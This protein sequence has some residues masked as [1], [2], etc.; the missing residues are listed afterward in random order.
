M[1]QGD[2]IFLRFSS[3]VCYVRIVDTLPVDIKIDLA[4]GV[5]ERRGNTDSRLR[6]K[7]GDHCISRRMPDETIGVFNRRDTS[8][9]NA[10]VMAVEDAQGRTAP[11]SD[12]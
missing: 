5:W 7:I 8:H 6:F 12:D 3:N 9:L 1:E 4:Q 2:L 10:L 11:T